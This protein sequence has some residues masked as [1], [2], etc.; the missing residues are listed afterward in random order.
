MPLIV[1]VFCDD[2]YLTESTVDP[3]GNPIPNGGTQLVSQSFSTLC[4][5]SA[6]ANNHS[7]GS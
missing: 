3:E 2:S 1:K 4:T 6:M 5:C 7:Q